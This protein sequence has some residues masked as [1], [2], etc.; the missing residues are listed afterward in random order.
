MILRMLRRNLRDSRSRYEK[1]IVIR[2]L[3]VLQTLSSSRPLSAQLAIRLAAMPISN[4]EVLTR[5]KAG[6]AL[7]PGTS[8]LLAT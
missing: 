3:G 4:N 6:I 8:G 5:C 7:V 2:N 1:D